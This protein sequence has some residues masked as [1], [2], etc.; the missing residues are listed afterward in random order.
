LKLNEV[1]QVK[2]EDLEELV[3]LLTGEQTTL[4]SVFVLT[5][6]TKRHKQEGFLVQKGNVLNV[7]L[8]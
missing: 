6:D 5:V 1:A 7:E 3:V 2:K 4:K 8:L